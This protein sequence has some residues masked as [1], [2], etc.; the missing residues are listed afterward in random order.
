M[1][2]CIYGVDSKAFSDEESVIYKEGASIVAPDFK[3]I[4]YFLLIQIF[5]FITKFYRMP[6][7]KPDTQA[8]FIKLVQDAIRM[9]KEQKIERDDYLNYLL[10]LKEKKNLP[11]IEVVAHTITF[12]LGKNFKRWRL[13]DNEEF[14]E[15]E[16]HNRNIV[17]NVGG[18]FLL[19]M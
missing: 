19:Y 8:F 9:R 18:K 16:I 2:S 15:D 11:D 4:L 13:N 6:F 14:R 1:S 17:N 7:I 3:F 12:F 5:P 10:Q